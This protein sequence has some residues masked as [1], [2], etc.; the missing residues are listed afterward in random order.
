M[1]KIRK[2]IISRLQATSNITDV[3]ELLA[4]AVSLEY[5]TIPPY[6][7]ALFSIKDGNQQARALVHSIVV[8]E[9]LHMTLAANTLIAIGGKPRILEDALKLYYPGPLPMCVD[10]GLTVT[11]A[12]LTKQQVGEVFMGIER[13][14]TTAIL[15]GEMA[16]RAEAA[17]T[18]Y[19]SIGVFYQAIL[20]KLGEL[21]AQGQHIFREP[22][23]EQQ[24]DISKWFPPEIKSFPDGKVHS[25][26][27]ATAALNTIIWQ[28]EGVQIRDDR[29]DPFEGHDGNYAH[30]FKFGEIF[31]GHR[32][33]PNRDAPS[34]WSY[35]GDAVPLDES[36]I[37][38]LKRNAALSDYPRGS[39]AQI[40]GKQFYEAYHSLLVALDQT[41]N[42]H[43]ERLNA[44]LGIMFELKL[45]AQQV[46]QF[47]LE[48][49]PVPLYAAPPFMRTHEPR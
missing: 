46:M 11:L 17:Q 19:A 10:E 29:I 39:G 1:L 38:N 4:G 44:A 28:G 20:K 26:E 27:S 6:L 18:S 13:P 12:S 24:I 3:Q 2:E 49:Q 14:D 47:R 15:P 41:F 30:Y 48:D 42:G 31:Y 32:L 36:N 7:T 23:L 40:A 33:V 22:R 5:S 25:M 37:I 43:P 45:V 16:L 34:G 35:T 21:V 8:E 9:M